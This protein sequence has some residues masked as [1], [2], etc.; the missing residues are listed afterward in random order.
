MGMTKA[1]S[2]NYLNV[3][4]REL[5]EILRVHIE[6]LGV[7]L[8]LLYQLNPKT[9]TPTERKRHEALRSWAEMLNENINRFQLELS[10][11]VMPNAAMSPEE[12]FAEF[13]A[14]SNFIAGGMD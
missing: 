5:F 3:L 6:T 10:S 2:T 7:L 11:R 8:G 9:M 14:L 12:A 1:E 13:E 4:N